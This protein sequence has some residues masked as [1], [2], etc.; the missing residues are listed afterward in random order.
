MIRAFSL[1]LHSLSDRRIIIL[2]IK[3]ILMTLVIFAL[4]GTGIWFLADYFIAGWLENEDGWIASTIAPIIAP[5]ITIATF[6]V[7]ILTGWFL[8]RVIA[9]T[10]V[11][12]FADDIIE[13]VE[14]RHY[15][16]AAQNGIRPG[17]KTSLHLAIRSLLR[18]IIYNLAALPFYLI[19]L[20]TAVGAP[21]IFLL[22]NA[23]L[24]GR[25]LDDMLGARHKLPAAA[26]S[27]PAQPGQKQVAISRWPR[28]GLGLVGTAGMMVP[29]VNFLVPVIA[30]AMAVHMMHIPDD[31]GRTPQT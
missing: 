30:T 21:I 27:P 15:P 1:S 11:W 13:A 18:V 4:L 9:I 26:D 29:I 23:L 12:F 16:D 24:L 8:F 2:L 10:V 14:E 7:T 6:L 25:D 31:T 3:S 22:V 5:V 19:L 17:F 28:W 20:F